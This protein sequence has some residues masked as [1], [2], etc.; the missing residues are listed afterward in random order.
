M[1]F[2]DVGKRIDERLLSVFRGNRQQVIRFKQAIKDLGGVL[3]GS[4]LLQC[5]VDETWSSS[6]IDIV[7]PNNHLQ[8]RSTQAIFSEICGDPDFSLLHRFNYL[9]FFS[10]LPGPSCV[11]NLLEYHFDDHL[12]Q[13]MCTNLETTE[14]V[15]AW[16]EENFDFSV[17]RNSAWVDSKWN[18]VVRIH[19]ED[20]IINRSFWF[21]S[22]CSL[23]SSFERK[24]KYEQRGFVVKMGSPHDLVLREA[25]KKGC[26]ISF[27]NFGYSR[28]NP[29]GRWD[30]CRFE[31]CEF[32]LLTNYHMH[33][34]VSSSVRS[35]IAGSEAFDALRTT[36]ILFAL[37][38]ARWPV[39]ILIEVLKWVKRCNTVFCNSVR[40][41]NIVK[42]IRHSRYTQTARLL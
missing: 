37:Q 32:N 13:L 18:W 14:R 38:N 6:D 7:L 16:I 21:D 40:L 22:F 4:F 28:L 41:W 9:N 35:I 11:R 39:L 8:V 33:G 17:V 26:Q 23:K 29:P 24:I 12:V 5:I 25:R 30:R 3:T 15:C 19:S 20:D 27:Y 34:L 31:D 1:S 36:E 10:G 2:G 42:T